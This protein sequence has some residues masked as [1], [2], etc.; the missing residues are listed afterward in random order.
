MPPY[1]TVNPKDVVINAP[2]AKAIMRMSK[3]NRG[4]LDVLS[5]KD[6]MDAA[7]AL[8]DPEN[9]HC[10]PLCDEYFPTNAFIAHAPQCILARAPRRK[11]WTPPGFSTNAIVAFPDTTG[12]WSDN[13]IY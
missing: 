9:E 6:E 7:K 8:G 11:V 3:I 10:C 2:V 12:Y 5:V 1:T 13:G 4:E